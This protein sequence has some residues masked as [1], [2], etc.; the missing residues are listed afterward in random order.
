MSAAGLETTNESAAP[1]ASKAYRTY[2]VW[3]L[4][5]IAL[6]NFFDR[7]IVNILAEPI[8]RD[9]GLSD[10][11]LGLLTGLA[12]ASLYTITGIPIAIIAD[13]TN[14]A[15]VIT[16]ALLVWSTFTAA[17]GLAQNYTQLLLARVVVGLG[18]SGCQPPSL[19][20]IADYASKE[21]RA[22]SMGTYSLGIS[23]GGL[24][25]LALGGVLADQFGW[26]VAF[27]LAGVPGILLAIVAGL[28][29]K[30][31]RANT[32]ASDRPPTRSVREC[33]AELKGNSVFWWV[34]LA[35][36]AK[37]LVS[38][39]Q[40]AFLG[41]FFLR[42]HQEGLAKVAGQIGDV[43]GL[44]LGP[45][46]MVGLGLGLISGIGGVFGTWLG[47]YLGDRLGRRDA[48]N[49]LLIP[50]IAA[51]L[52]IPFQVAAFLTPD[53][54]MALLLLIPPGVL[55]ALWLGPT[56]AAL[57][58]VVRPDTRATAASLQSSFVLFLGLGLGPLA[59]GGISDALAVGFGE[60]GG[61][62]WSLVACSMF[63]LVAAALFWAG[64]RNLKT[65]II[66]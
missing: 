9:L 52:S 14:R 8:K 26:R 40:V 41:S 32:S 5:C 15:R 63:G 58:S 35:S 28:T 42:V 55:G 30:D 21:K 27:F 64:S 20:L 45:L 62:R 59:V 49:L 23:V 31:P 53:T 65:A 25:A 61:V 24:V 6:I 17:C 34:C 46:A 19:S 29:L 43:T 7:Q 57:Q 33:F 12:F 1:A 56:F 22:S 36:A 10:L 3:L 44:H 18:E 47:G 50:A 60:A 54:G 13:R 2:V 37:A 4:F 16:G 48:T 51:P 38:Y 11:Q 39:G 66:S